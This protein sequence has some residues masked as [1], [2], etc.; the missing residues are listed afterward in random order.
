MADKSGSR[1]C[2]AI[3][4]EAC[5]SG[6]REERGEAGG[7]EPHLLVAEVADVDG[8]YRCCGDFYFYMF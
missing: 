8:R 6:A 1:Y 3:C 4:G 7:S 5:G 2:Y